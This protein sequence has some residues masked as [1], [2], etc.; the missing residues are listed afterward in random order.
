MAM[1][2]NEE[3]R[4]LRDTAREFL[5]ARAPVAALRALRDD[6]D[7]LGWSRELWAEMAGLG[8][9]GIVI[10]EE[11]GG[12]EF[13]FTGLGAVLQETGRTLTASPLYATCV[14]G[15]SAILLA[16]DQQQKQAVL[17]RVATGD[18]SGCGCA[19]SA[20]GTATG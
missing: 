4:H 12:L 15:A 3:Q 17:P 10:P 5:L 11:F 14:L 8:W 2:L 9:A 1:T 18:R 19:P 7:P 16:G 6:R 20:T 13:G